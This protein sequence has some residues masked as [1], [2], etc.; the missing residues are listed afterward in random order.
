M[1]V[2]VEKAL[3]LVG[4]EFGF[5]AGQ[6]KGRYEENANSMEVIVI[7]SITS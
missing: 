6:E 1:G 2:R 5:Y 7:S 4:G 3:A